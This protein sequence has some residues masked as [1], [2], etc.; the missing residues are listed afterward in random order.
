MYRLFHQG[1]NDALLRRR[2]EVVAR[3]DDERA[4]TLAFTRHGRRNGWKDAPEYLLRSLPAHAAGAGLADDL[5]RDDAYLLHADLRRLIQAA[6]GAG[7]AAGAP[8]RPAAAADPAGHH[9]GPGG[10]GRLVQRHRG[11]R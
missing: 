5:L 8:S 3:A 7:S 11:P 4:L 1:L 9:R 2:S 10:P 6:D